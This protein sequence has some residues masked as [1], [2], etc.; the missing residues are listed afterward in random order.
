MRD[1]KKVKKDII[2][3][4][5]LLEGFNS[6][7]QSQRLRNRAREKGNRVDWGAVVDGIYENDLKCKDFVAKCQYEKE[8]R[9]KQRLR[10]KP[11]FKIFPKSSKKGI[12]EL[13]EIIKTQEDTLSK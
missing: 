2:N 12:K 3:S 5:F 8:L 1:F 9:E 11:R 6:K 10:R 7:A 13:R 4:Q